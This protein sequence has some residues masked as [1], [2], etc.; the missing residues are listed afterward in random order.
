MLVYSPISSMVVSEVQGRVGNR[1]AVLETPHGFDGILRSG[2]LFDSG[3]DVD[4]GAVVGRGV[5]GG[6]GGDID[7]AVA[8]GE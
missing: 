6:I 5:D 4:G 1:S 3:E 7:L 8:G 2:V